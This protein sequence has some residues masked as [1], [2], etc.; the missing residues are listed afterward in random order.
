MFAI[1]QYCQTHKKVCRVC[2]GGVDLFQFFIVVRRVKLENLVSL[3]LVHQWTNLSFTS[4]L[5]RLQLIWIDLFSS[6]IMHRYLVH[7]LIFLLRVLRINYLVS[8]LFR[9]PW[10]LIWFYWLDL[11]NP[12]V[13]GAA[14]LDVPV[15]AT[16]K[17]VFCFIYPYDHQ[18]DELANIFIRKLLIHC[19]VIHQ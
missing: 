5:L 6:Q 10:I 7:A 4:W 13:H 15:K 3:F 1:P 16:V 18:Y 14:V 17:E 2:P 9:L 12:T 11:R 19:I 8:N